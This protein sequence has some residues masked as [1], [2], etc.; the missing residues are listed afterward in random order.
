MNNF[1][2]AGLTALGCVAV[3]GIVQLA[4]Y[5]GTMKWREDVLKHAAD[6]T[7]SEMTMLRHARRAPNTICNR[8]VNKTIGEAL[9]IY[10]EKHKI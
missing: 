3:S 10:N 6:M 1:A 7:E 2:I 5:P 4:K 9:C 8:I